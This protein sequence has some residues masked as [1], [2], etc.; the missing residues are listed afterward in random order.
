MNRYGW[1]ILN[2]IHVSFCTDNKQC[3]HKNIH[4]KQLQNANPD[5]VTLKFADP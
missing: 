5:L 4:I 1:A 3:F 2:E